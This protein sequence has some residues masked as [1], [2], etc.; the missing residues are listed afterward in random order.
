MEWSLVWFHIKAFDRACPKGTCRK[1]DPRHLVW[2]ADKLWPLSLAVY[3]QGCGINKQ[4]IA[5]PCLWMKHRPRCRAKQKKVLLY[6][7]VGVSPTSSFPTWQNSAKWPPI[8][9]V[10]HETNFTTITVFMHLFLRYFT[11]GPEVS[12]ASDI[13]PRNLCSA[14]TRSRWPRRSGFCF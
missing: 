5:T 1:V 7:L 12:F 4:D 8:T 13:T 9:H 10:V 6:T 3:I 14:L 2:Q 11:C